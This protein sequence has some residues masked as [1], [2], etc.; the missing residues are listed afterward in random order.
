MCEETANKMKIVRE[1]SEENKKCEEN[2]KISE[3]WWIKYNAAVEK[4]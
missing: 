3:I 1:N 2:E 4:D